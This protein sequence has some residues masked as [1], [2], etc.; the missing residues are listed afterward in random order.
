MSEKGS[1]DE[2]IQE[3]KST[4]WRRKRTKAFEYKESPHQKQYGGSHLYLPFVLMGYLQVLFNVAIVSGI[5]YFVIQFAL[6]IRK[7]VDIKVE[8]HLNSML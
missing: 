3:S 8:E 1:D 7:D 6:T 5:L 2:E 4:G